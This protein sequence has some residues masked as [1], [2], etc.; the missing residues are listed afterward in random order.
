[1]ETVFSRIFTL[2]VDGRPT[3]AFEASGTKQAKE[4][5]RESWLLD[6]LSSLTS[7]GERLRTSKSKLSV[8]L[9][10]PDEASIFSLAANT[11]EDASDDMVL[12][13]LVNLDGEED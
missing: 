13:Y 6:D 4:I 7:S 11:M 8:R 12:V 1:M 9:A 10:S 3:L 5:C 2:E